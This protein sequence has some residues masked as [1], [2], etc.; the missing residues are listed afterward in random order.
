MACKTSSKCICIY[1]WHKIEI[2]HL[3]KIFLTS[4]SH[5]TDHSEV[6]INIIMTNLYK[7][8]KRCFL[9]SVSVFIDSRWCRERT[10]WLKKRISNLMHLEQFNTTT[11]FIHT[12]LCSTTTYMRND[13]D[14]AFRQQVNLV[15]LNCTFN[16][17][18]EKI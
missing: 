18:D 13:C 16:H 12:Q 2:T 10:E 1:I 15:K 5:M 7:L 17:G 3:S 8:N 9:L 14:V 4:R 6:C 11:N